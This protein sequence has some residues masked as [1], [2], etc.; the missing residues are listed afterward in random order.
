VCVFKSPTTRTSP[1][2]NSEVQRRSKRG[3]VLGSHDAYP[4]ELQQ[5]SSGTVPD[6]PTCS[7]MR[8]TV[9][10]LC[11]NLESTIRSRF[12]FAL[13]L[14]DQ[15]SLLVLGILLHSRHPCQKHPSTKTA[16]FMPGKYKSGCPTRRER[17]RYPRMP[18][19][20]SVRRRIISGFVFSDLTADMH[21][22]RCSLVISST[23]YSC[24][25]SDGAS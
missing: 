21:L 15:N 11:A 1:D 13:I 25:S 12:L 2:S 22:R 3:G 19:C 16:S 18:L 7:H 14:R 4:Q 24:C 23:G 17:R 8:T 10:P 6:R 5:S 9:I 20:H